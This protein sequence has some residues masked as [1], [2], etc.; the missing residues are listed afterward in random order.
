MLRLSHSAQVMVVSSRHTL[1][2]VHTSPDERG[3]DA[4]QG[5]LRRGVARHATFSSRDALAAGHA[6]AHRATYQA[7]A[8]AFEEALEELRVL[9]VRAGRHASQ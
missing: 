9:A 3:G 6:I 7:G 8:P 2:A 1:T 5:D 4:D